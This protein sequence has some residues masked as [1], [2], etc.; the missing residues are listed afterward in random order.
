ML[1][2]NLLS[3]IDIFPI[4][5]FIL[6]NIFLGKKIFSLKRSFLVFDRFSVKTVNILAFS[7]F[8]LNHVEDEK[9]SNVQNAINFSFYSCF[10]TFLFGE[11]NILD[12]FKPIYGLNYHDWQIRIV[13]G[14]IDAEMYA[15]GARLSDWDDIKIRIEGILGYR[16]Q[17]KTI[18][19]AE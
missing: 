1:G 7:V 2:N 18:F 4:T 5:I 11:S 16:Q 19:P 15:V 17:F 12:L 8:L 9:I 6:R 13:F 10:S 14:I 3:F